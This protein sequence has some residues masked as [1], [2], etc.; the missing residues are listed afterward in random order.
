MSDECTSRGAGSHV[1]SNARVEEKP[2]AS[3][4][5]PALSWVSW[6]GRVNR[7]EAYGDGR[8]IRA[9][10][11][12]VMR[13]ATSRA[14]G[15][16]DA[17]RFRCS[18]PRVASPTTGSMWRAGSPPREG[19]R[20]GREPRHDQVR[21]RGLSVQREARHEVLQRLLRARR[22]NDGTALQLPARGVQIVR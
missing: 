19:A 6:E 11:V 4:L 1:S 17:E 18:G 21:T 22:D 7:A 5:N 2:T 20:H 15:E 14:S 12:A 8:I 9:K 13:R 16:R 10:T 3:G